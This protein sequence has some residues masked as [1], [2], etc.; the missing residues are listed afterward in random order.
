MGDYLNSIRNLNPEEV[1]TIEE[2]D[3]P[4]IED[5]ARNYSDTFS[6]FKFYPKAYLQ[7]KLAYLVGCAVIQGRIAIIDAAEIV[8]PGRIEEEGANAAV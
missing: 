4:S 1:L 2:E 8:I 5:Q 7:G 3:S 6:G